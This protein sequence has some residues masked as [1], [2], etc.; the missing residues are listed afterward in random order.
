MVTP[1][2]PLAGDR[3]LVSD[4]CEQR[5]AR[6]AAPYLLVVDGCLLGSTLSASLRAL[7][8]QV[9]CAASGQEALN[10]LHSAAIDLVLLDISLR[11]T[12]GYA[13]CTQIRQQ[14]QLPVVVM[15][16]AR[17]PIDVLLAYGAGADAYIQKPFRLRE[18]VEKVQET[19]RKAM[20]TT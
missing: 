12:N 9:Y 10:I 5:A 4:R 6:G 20:P 19:L 13:L 11:D 16:A 17:G 14:F 1:V 18:L 2:V 7:G 15:S 8:F 3:S